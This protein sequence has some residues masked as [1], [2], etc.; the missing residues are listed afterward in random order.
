L[1]LHQEPSLSNS[2]LSPPYQN[3]E[4]QINQLT[5]LPKITHLQDRILADI[6]ARRQE[7]ISTQKAKENIDKVKT[8]TKEEQKQAWQNLENQETEKG[9]QNN[10]EEIN[11]LKKEQAQK[12]PQ[13]YSQQAQQR[14]ENKLRD[15]QV[16]IADLTR[17]NQ[18]A[19]QKLKEG[20]ITDPTQL[21]ETENNLKQNIYQVE[22]TKKITDLTTRVQQVLQSKSKSQI[23]ILKKEL[24]EFISSGNIYYSAKKKEAENLLEKLECFES[25]P[26]QSS[27]TSN[28][29]EV[30]WKAI[31]SILVVGVIVLAAV[32]I[33]I[34]K[35]T[36]L[37]KKT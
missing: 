16:Q 35:D 25:N 36:R 3:W 37:K 15:N 13:E 31:V 6:Q 8:G 1:A 19:F 32:V 26:N 12:D 4:E 14:I 20:Q 30:P 10:Q 27:S 7:K 23:T 22:A 24:L 2:E 5:D 29:S 9:F 21:V 34:K 33:R 18:Q 11:N 28:S 17:D